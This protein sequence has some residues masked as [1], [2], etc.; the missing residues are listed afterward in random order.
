M[1]IKGLFCSMISLTMLFT[2]SCSNKNNKETSFDSSSFESE[3]SDISMTTTSSEESSLSTHIHTY[4]KGWIEDKTATS[5][6]KGLH[7][8]ICD[9]CGETQYEDIN[10]TLDFPRVYINYQDFYPTA[11]DAKDYQGFMNW[12]WEYLTVPIKYEG[13]S[14]D[15]SHDFECFAQMKIQ[16]GTSKNADYL[17]KNYTIKLFE[18]RE[19]L[20]KNKISIVDSWGAQSKYVLKANW[21]DITSARNLVTARIWS[22]VVESRKTSQFVSPRD[23]VDLM[24]NN[25]AIDGFPVMLYFNNEY[26]GLYTFNIPKDNWLFGM[27]KSNT[28][29]LLFAEGTAKN[30]NGSLYQ[31]TGFKEL[32]NWDNTSMTGSGWELEYAY[33]ETN[34]TWVADSM[35]NAISLVMNTYGKLK[36]SMT[37]EEKQNLKNQFVTEAP[38]YLDI[39]GIIDYM[40]FLH[41]IQGFPDNSTKNVM[42]STYDG[43]VWSPN[44]YDL[45]TT[46]NM[47]WD[48]QIGVFEDN[49]ID[50]RTGG[51]WIDGWYRA[52]LR[53]NALFETI[54]LF[55]AEQAQNRFNEL[56]KGPL[57]YD[58]ISNRFTSFING[59]PQELYDREAT[60]YPTRPSEQI[61]SITGKKNTTNLDQILSFASNLLQ[62]MDEEYNG[63]KMFH[64][65][66]YFNA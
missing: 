14:S 31:S 41:C 1:K 15:K 13:F 27:K 35:N 44:A 38:N 3:S 26:F 53:G 59:I 2:F 8:R 54:L 63:S 36:D 55:Y 4:S 37:I 45:D 16:G 64:N 46:W 25:G 23:N 22:D 56:R 52:N 47:S 39:D 24:I 5:F 19:C 11:P 6:E 34:T 17:K 10:Y 62:F 40:I 7:H 33:D 49:V 48:G 60:D 12:T 32:I 20:I 43:K 9:G 50:H 66:N 30:E 61:S 28:Q 18:D 51:F 58:N 29:A 57:S 42:W 65:I 21:I